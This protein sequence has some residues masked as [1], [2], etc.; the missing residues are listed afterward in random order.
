[1]LTWVVVAGLGLGSTSF[2][3][4]CAPLD[5]SQTPKRSRLGPV[6][7]ALGGLRRYNIA[8][9]LDNKVCSEPAFTPSSGSVKC[10]EK[11][12]LAIWPWLIC[13]PSF[14]LV[15]SLAKR[16]L[17]SALHHAWYQPG[18]AEANAPVYRQELP[19]LSVLFRVTATY[20]SRTWEVAR[21]S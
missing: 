3:S 2:I 10:L 12:Q 6:S 20:Y 5:L 18:R 21:A 1:M 11:L 17:A 8:Y 19:A 7:M 15:T 13:L 14:A 9:T 16:P 4:M